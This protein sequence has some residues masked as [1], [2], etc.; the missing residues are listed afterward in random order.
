MNKNINMA[1]QENR[2]FQRDPFSQK[3]KT[4]KQLL[5]R[6]LGVEKKKFVVAAFEKKE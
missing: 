4:R 5:Q 1:L 3:N 2:F 6:F